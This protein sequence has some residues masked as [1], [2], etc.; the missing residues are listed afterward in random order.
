MYQSLS[1]Q[2]VLSDIALDV[3]FIFTDVAYLTKHI[4]PILLPSDFL[5][6]SDCDLTQQGIRIV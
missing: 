4:T 1:I 6:E 2:E 5:W 3:D